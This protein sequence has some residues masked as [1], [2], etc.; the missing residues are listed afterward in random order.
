MVFDITLQEWRRRKVTDEGTFHPRIF[1]MS[2]GRVTFSHSQDSSLLLNLTSNHPA[3]SPCPGCPSPEY[4]PCRVAASGWVRGGKRR[5]HVAVSQKGFR[6]PP[7]HPPTHASELSRQACAILDFKH[8][9]EDTLQYPVQ[10]LTVCQ[11]R[12]LWTRLCRSLHW[13]QSKIFCGGGRRT[14][15]FELTKL[16]PGSLSASASFGTESRP[17]LTDLAITVHC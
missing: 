16:I 8:H 15:E 1:N 9:T 10:L 5:G 12:I 7:L 2:G 13:L 11:A 14:C 6:P 3:L 4:N 17:D